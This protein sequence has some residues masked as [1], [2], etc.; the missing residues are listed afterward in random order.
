MQC[1]HLV[2]EIKGGIHVWG[3]A[4]L[5]SRALDFPQMAF[6]H[7]ML[8]MFLNVRLSQRAYILWFVTFS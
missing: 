4:W 3:G 2:Q 5:W 6:F 7:K 8:S 1:E